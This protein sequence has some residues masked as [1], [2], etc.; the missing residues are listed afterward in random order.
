MGTRK[1]KRKRIGKLFQIDSRTLKQIQNTNNEVLSQHVIR[2]A[3]IK[4]FR[5]ADELDFIKS[6]DK[7]SVLDTI[8]NFLFLFAIILLFFYA[9]SNTF[10]IVS[11]LFIVISVIFKIFVWLKLKV[12]IYYKFDS[13]L[14]APIIKEHEQRI[15]AWKKFFSSKKVWQINS[16]GTFSRSKVHGGA[17]TAVVRSK[18]KPKRRLPPYLKTNE[19]FI[20]LKLRSQTLIFLPDKILIKK[21]IRYGVLSY[22]EVKIF[23]NK[24]R[25]V[26]DLIVPR[27]AYVVS[28]TWKYV[29]KNG[30]RDKR[31][32][33]NYEVS[34]CLYG[35]VTLT[36]AN[37][38][39]VMLECSDYKN[40]DSFR[41]YTY[42]KV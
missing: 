40:I 15:E 4:N 37:G 21:I 30:T 13:K 19:N 32:N 36:S 1:R 16:Q 20:Y 27:D 29:N 24:T 10:P 22:D 17:S 25:F 18:I 31:F 2:S 35:D 5:S 38:L 42:G 33:N 23:T 6:L 39:N 11:I 12:F 28:K 3:G 8:S 41:Q 26:E 9:F 14:D 34:V 7:G